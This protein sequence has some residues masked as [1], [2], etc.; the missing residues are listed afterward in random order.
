MWN[1]WMAEG[2]LGVVVKMLSWWNSCP[3]S[4]SKAI[5]CLAKEV[6]VNYFLS[7]SVS[8]S[9]ADVTVGNKVVVFLHAS[10]SD[11]YG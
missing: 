8:S 1:I 7:P 2:I 5:T 3:L 4:S 11:S 6:P 9:P 10:M